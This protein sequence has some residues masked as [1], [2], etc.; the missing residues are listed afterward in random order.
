MFNPNG[1]YELIRSLV[2][3]VS[4]SFMESAKV[5]SS[6]G[7][8]LAR[9]RGVVRIRVRILHQVDQE[10]FYGLQPFPSTG[11]SIL[12]IWGAEFRPSIAWIGAEFCLDMGLD[13]CR[14]LS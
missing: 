10:G 1:S 2:Y 12:W 4:V 13:W 6:G 8:A 11:K 5:G 14:I 9:D 7:G 3:T